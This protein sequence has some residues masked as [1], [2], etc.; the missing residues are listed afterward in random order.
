MPRTAGSFEKAVQ[1]IRN[2]RDANIF[3]QI[4]TYASRENVPEGLERI[5]ALARKL[6]VLAV[7]VFFPMAVGRW[8]ADFD[9]A[10]TDEER[11]QV[12]ALQDVSLVHLELPT[13]G[14]MCCSYAKA[15]VYVTAHGDVTPCPFVPYVIGN[16][17]EHTLQEVWQRH[18]AELKLVC[19]GACPM[20]FPGA[21]DALK[22]HA[23]RVSGLFEA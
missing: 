10:L 17:R 22:C 7:F 11:T 14:T 4:L 9:Q 15:V 3:C 21:R 8:E 6:K 23:E 18:C 13:P 16:I 20:N 12:R 19:R 1:G 5:F 2:L